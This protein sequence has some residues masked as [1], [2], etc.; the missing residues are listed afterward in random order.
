MIRTEQIF[1]YRIKLSKSSNSLAHHELRHMLRA[2]LIE[3]GLEIAKSKTGPR[4][5]LGPAAGEGESSICQYA[6]ICLLKDTPLQEI[7][8][9]LSAFISGGFNI[10]DVKE[11]PY[12]IC[13]VESLAQYALYTIVGMHADTDKI[14]KAEKIEV[15]VMHE[16]GIREFVNIKPHICS[17]KKI[18]ENKLELVAELGVLRRFGLRQILT[19]LPGSEVDERQLSIQRSALLWKNSVGDL[20]AV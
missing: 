13:S 8:S 9:K 2:A 6:D 17:I 10:I 7:N 1:K 4:L 11:V 14:S 19:A 5:A 3:S 15:E 16:N 12:A 18:S 20:N